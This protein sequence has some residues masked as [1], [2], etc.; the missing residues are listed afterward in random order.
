[1][2][3]SESGIRNAARTRRLILETS[4]EVLANRGSAATVA[5]IATAA[6]VSKGGVL[7]HF[8]SRDALLLAVTEYTLDSFR[9]RVLTDV[10]LSE[11]YP[12]KVLRAYIRVITA[13]DERDGDPYRS[14]ALW[15]SVQMIP[16]VSEI[17]R[18]DSAEWTELLER[19]GLN[20]DRAR[21]IRHAAE[22]LAEAR[23]YE[24]GSISDAVQRERC[25]LLDLT[26]ANG[27][28]A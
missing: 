2:T 14:A 22:G 12:G 24:P 6:G 20:S 15:N 23:Y 27:P 16:G 9:A 4:A 28:L 11:N 8:G 25:A 1:M 5:D 19:D 10:D 17:L 21:I 18:R 3:S 13:D 26:R 7:H